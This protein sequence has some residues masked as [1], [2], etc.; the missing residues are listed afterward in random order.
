MGRNCAGRFMFT[1]TMTKKVT[2]S[3]NPIQYYD[4]DSV[5]AKTNYCGTNYLGS[6]MDFML[7]KNYDQYR[8]GNYY[9]WREA[10]TTNQYGFKITYGNGDWYEGYVFAG[11][12]YSNNAYKV[13]YT[14]PFI[15][16]NGLWGNYQ[17]TAVMGYNKNIDD[18][19]KVFVTKYHDFESI[20]DFQ[21]V[22]NK[23]GTASGTNYLGSEMDWILKA[24]VIEQY[25]FGEYYG[26]REA[27]VT[28]QY[29]YNYTYGK[30]DK[31]S[32]YFY[33][34]TDKGYYLGYKS[35][36]KDDDSKFGAYNVTAVSYLDASS[37]N[38]S[39]VHN[40][41]VFV[42]TYYDKET[43][44]STA[45]VNYTSPLGTNYLGSEWGYIR[46]A[47]VDQY[48]FG[49]YYGL[50]READYTMRYSYTFNYADG[51]YYK[52]YVYAVADPSFYVLN[53]PVIVKKDEN[54]RWGS[55]IITGT[56]VRD[57]DETKNGQVWINS[58]YYKNGNLVGTYTPFKKQA[59]TYAGTNY[60]QSEY[61]YIITN[62]NGAYGFGQGYYEVNPGL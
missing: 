45:P 60:L 43:N 52:G 34:S 6:E 57:L 54:G 59:N 17:V 7:K 36:A 48:R 62:N 22:N 19:G 1:I 56:P 53:R 28:A 11:S 35:V 26:K 24:G 39:Y 5:A 29:T 55:Y 30:G 18:N 44:S 2:S 9:G 16:E 27:D 12:D 51:D 4:P 41:K 3:F 61:D 58:Y 8:F 31:Y 14:S 46:K 42:Q 38:Y 10:D 21:P 37:L 50:V 33:A 32:G 49:M 25:R 23:A 13:G 15:D 47:D 40:G 20:Q